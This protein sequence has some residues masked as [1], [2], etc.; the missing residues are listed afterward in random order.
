MRERP[1]PEGLPSEARAGLMRAWLAILRERHPG[2]LCLPV[3]ESPA[4][5]NERKRVHRGDEGFGVQSTY[6][7]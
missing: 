5:E 6:L 2:V 3:I 7:R 1:T 4:L